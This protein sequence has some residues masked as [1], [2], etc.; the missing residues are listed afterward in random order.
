[1][2]GTK[3]PFASRLWEKDIYVPE[4]ASENTKLRKERRAFTLVGGKEKSCF[5]VITS[6]PEK[7]NERLERMDSCI[8]LVFKM[9]YLDQQHQNYPGACQK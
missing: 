8:A 1:M 4:K 7:S 3:G 5:F 9:W 2:L 6:A